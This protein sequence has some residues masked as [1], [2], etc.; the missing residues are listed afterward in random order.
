M[1]DRE[2]KVTMQSKESTGPTDRKP[3][4]EKIRQIF[5]PT[6]RKLLVRAQLSR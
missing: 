6:S 2:R 5:I 3:L 1:N 4:R